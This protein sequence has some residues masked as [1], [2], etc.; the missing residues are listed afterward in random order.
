MA[1]EVRGAVQH[2]HRAR[3]PQF[4]QHPADL[5]QHAFAHHGAFE[6]CRWCSQKKKISENYNPPPTKTSPLFL[7]TAAYPLGINVVAKS[8]PERSTPVKSVSRK[9]ATPISAPTNFAPLI[10]ANLKFVFRNSAP[11]KLTLDRSHR[12]NSIPLACASDKS[13]PG[14]IASVKSELRKSTPC[15]LAPDKSA[16]GSFAFRRSLP[17]RLAPVNIAP[18]RFTP[19]KSA[20]DKSAPARLA[21]SPPSWPR[22]NRSCASRISVN[23]FP[24]CVML[25]AFFNPIVDCP[26]SVVPPKQQMLPTRLPIVLPLMTLPKMPSLRNRYTIPSRCRSEPLW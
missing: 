8:T 5:L 20:P 21:R 7:S 16:P 1:L 19:L 18:L 15:I 11:S 13:A 12:K 17:A 3:T 14:K 10:F 22:K 24:L 2:G 6:L 23:F 9:I 26:R 4:L 25:F